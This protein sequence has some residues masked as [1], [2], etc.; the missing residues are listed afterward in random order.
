MMDKKK[1]DLFENSSIPRAAMAL[2]IPTV[3]STLVM[4]FYNIAD[5]YFV[6]L[7]VDPIESAAV[8]LAAPVL[9]A[10]NAINNLFGIGASSMMSRSLGKKDY[11]TVKKC[12]SFS[13]YSALV[14]ALIIS[15][16]CTVFISPLLRLLGA[17]TTTS[18]ATQRYMLWT[19][20]FGAAPAILNVVLSNMVRSEGSS[21]HASIGVMSGCILN[22][23]LDPFFVLP[24]FL[25]MG[26]AGAGLATLISN[27]VACL[28]FFV[29]LFVKRSS[30]YVSLSP[31]D[32]AF[33]KDIIK[34]VLGVGIP[35]SVQNLLNVTGSIILNNFTAVFGADAVTAMGISHKINMIPMYICMGGT[36]GIM[37]L[38]SYNYSSGNRE[39][40]KKAITF[41]GRLVVAS[42]AVMTVVIFIFS[43]DIIRL[44][45]NDD[46]VVKYGAPILRGMSIGIVF[47]ALDFLAVGVFQAIGKGLYS[48]VFAILR[49][50]VLEIPA[51][52]ILNKVYPLYGMGYAATCAEVVLAVAAVIML[53]KIMKEKPASPIAE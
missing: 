2:C 17:D 23:I 35:A 29:L 18:D 24:R 49:K 27:C 28:Y 37:P 15:V 41:I 11:E 25:G 14:C 3:L 6:G 8:T 19:V 9:L 16:L 1:L 34:E 36:Q 31:I 45:M 33:R 22:V 51:I 44:F 10:F 47:L 5:T 7:L 20:T 52:I 50:L 42:A 12:A 53:R 21:V 38:V 43:G 30:T 48:F 46:T 32:F 40:M 26:A 13:F 39:R 4:V